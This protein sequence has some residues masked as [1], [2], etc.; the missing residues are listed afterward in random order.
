LPASAWTATARTFAGLAAALALAGG[1]AAR[2]APVQAP[3]AGYS[4]VQVE[5][6]RWRVGYAGKTVTSR[7]AAEAYLLYRSAELTLQQGAEWFEIVDRHGER[8][9]YVWPDPRFSPWRAYGAWRPQWRYDL[10]RSGG[11]RTWD[12]WR[13]DPFWADTVDPQTVERFEVAAEIVIRRGPK[14]A[15][16]PRAFDARAVIADLRPRIR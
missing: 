1:F 16:D 2:T 3:P 14:P 9:A 8:D 13:G 11:W 4:E 7:E 5:P 10:A 12:P 15:N 6:G